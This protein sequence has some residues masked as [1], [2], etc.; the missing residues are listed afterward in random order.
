MG[1]LTVFQSALNYVIDT[2][3]LHAASAVA[4]LHFIR[5]ISAASFPLIVKPSEK[6]ISYDD[7]HY[8]ISDI[9]STVFYNLGTKW[10]GSTLGFITVALTPVPYLYVYLPLR[11]CKLVLFDVL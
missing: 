7:C 8:I 1:F 6:I 3:E 5:S 9:L 10:A 11:N 4:A 2:F